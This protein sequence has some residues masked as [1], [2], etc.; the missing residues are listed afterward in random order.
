MKNVSWF[1]LKFIK[2]DHVFEVDFLEENSLKLCKNHF[3]SDKTIIRGK[4]ICFVS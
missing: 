3:N 2:H 4:T 1:K